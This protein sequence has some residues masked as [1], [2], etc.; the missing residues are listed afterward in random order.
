[1]AANGNMKGVAPN[2]GISSYRVFGTK[3]AKSSWI[4]KA[5]ITAA[6]DGAML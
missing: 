3:S 1:M 5:I 6:N 4:I 2:I